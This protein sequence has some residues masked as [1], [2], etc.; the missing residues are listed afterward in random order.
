MSLLKNP[1]AS[2]SRVY[3]IY[4]L[5]LQFPDR[6]IHPDTLRRLIMPQA[7][8]STD[9]N[10]TDFVGDSL[11]ELTNLGLLVQDKDGM[12]SI[13][14]ALPQEVLQATKVDA[15]LPHLIREWT[16]TSDPASNQNEDLAKTIAW[17]MTQ[18]PYS[19]PGNWKAVEEAL[20]RQ[21]KTKM[22]CSSDARYGQFEDWILYFGLAKRILKQLI[23]DPTQVIRYYLPQLFYDK[24]T[25]NVEE[26]VK[27]LAKLCPVLEQGR[28]RDWVNQEF[29]VE[30]S[31]PEG[32]LSQSSSL[33]WLRLH[34]EKYVLLDKKSD[35]DV[36]IFSE[37]KN[38]YRYSEI[39]W[40]A[41]EAVR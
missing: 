20:L 36:Y 10:E 15:S 9:R 25:H 39:T 26:I 1:Q 3:A 30:S 14:T 12:L 37:F 8:A 24:R 31:L 40:Q 41:E 5:T 27:R 21:L 22:D 2:P 38:T 17:Y 19:A 7:F 29:G 35:D 13:N 16:L 28:Y 18:N 33:A 32:H 23:P 11:R 4:R 6:R 34:E